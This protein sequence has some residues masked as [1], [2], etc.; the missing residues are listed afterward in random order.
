MRSRAL[1]GALGL[2]LA[3]AAL[4]AAPAGAAC[5]QALALGLDVSGSV[6]AAEYRLQLDGLAAAL[7][8]PEVQAAFLDVPGT[9]VRLMI[10]EWS[11]E[12][13]QRPLVGWTEITGA[14]RLSGIAGRLRAT[15]AT[16]V[17]NPSTAIGAA[18]LYGARALRD[19][20]G[21]WQRTLD[22][23]GDGPANVGRHPRDVPAASMAGITVN[24]LVIGPDG[25]AN[26]T[27]DLTNVKSL[28]GYYRSFVLRGPDSFAEAA[29]DYADFER[30]MRRK[31]IRELR[32]VAVSR[33]AGPEHAAGRPQ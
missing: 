25:R 7:L 6:D 14:G 27:K 29:L 8:D 4:P 26:T 10:F 3:S 13:H 18:M 33:R 19:Q 1:L 24:G 20:D 28:L 32:P 5:R 17:Q 31:L 30:A 22:I 12:G 11:G 15:R 23:S 2:A 9:P 16:P 21:C